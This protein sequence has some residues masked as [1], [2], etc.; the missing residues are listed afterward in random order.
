MDD[1]TQKKKPSWL[2]RL[3]CRAKRL[4]HAVDDR[5][6]Q[7]RFGTFTAQRSALLAELREVPGGEEALKEARQNKVKIRVVSPRRI[8]GVK[9][10]FSPRKRG[11]L[12][13]ISSC[14]DVP[15]MTSTLWHELRHLCQHLARGD[16]KGGSTRLLDTRVQHMTSLMMEADA[17]TSQTMMCLQQKRAGKPEYLEAFL[18]R[19]SAACQYIGAFLDQNPPEG[20]K[21]DAQ[22]ARALFSGV[23]KDGL[24]RYQ[25]KYFDG[26]RR[27]FKKAATAEALRKMVAKKRVR[28]FIPSASL[29][30]LYG[31]RA[32]GV[33]PIRPLAQTLYDAQP[34]D[35]R[36]TLALIEETVAKA[37]MLPAEDFAAARSDI[38]ARTKALSKTFKTA[39][40]TPPKPPKLKPASRNP[41]L[42]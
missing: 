16:L 10:R 42:K 38:L 32:D 29:L 33:S 37:A 40:S 3:G 35:V 34:K 11:A 6:V 13:R 7:R 28:E 19:D 22:F 9:G 2:Q 27:A 30:Q 39:A 23:V 31:R 17:Y 15:R 1:A 24:A 14:G 8:D 18:K 36:D 21:D 20:F 41:P 4:F 26:Y 5:W 25:C 12:L